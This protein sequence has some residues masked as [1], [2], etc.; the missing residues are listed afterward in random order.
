M[1]QPALW[2]FLIWVASQK[3]CREDNTTKEEHNPAISVT[4]REEILEHVLILPGL[5][6]GG[7][8]HTQ[9]NTRSY[10]VT[11]HFHPP[12][13]ANRKMLGPRLWIGGGSGGGEAKTA[14]EWENETQGCKKT[15][16]EGGIDECLLFPPPASCVPALWLDASTPSPSGKM[17]CIC[18]ITNILELV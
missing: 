3:H 2:K 12:R 8:T 14:L 6:V 18:D 15:R 17:S 11:I 13:A 9:L 10:G 5:G 7:H 1:S 16:E 4:G